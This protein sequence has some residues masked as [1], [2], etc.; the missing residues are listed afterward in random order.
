MPAPIHIIGGGLAGS[1]AAWQIAE[2][3]HS[4]IL[5]E[6]RPVV[7]TPAH[8][9][10]RFAELV[11]SN[12]LKSEQPDTAPWLLKQELRRLGSL[13]LEAAAHARVPGG[14]ALTVDREVFSTEITRAIAA[15]PRIEVRREEVRQIDDQAGISIVASGPLTSDTL[16]GEIARLTGSG[17]LFFYDSISPIVEADSVDLTIAFRASRY[18]KS[19]DGTRRLSE[20]PVRSPSIRSLH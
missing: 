4:A 10:D 13:V 2:S 19:L 5:H 20:L 6:M 7:Q 18:G 17:R 1:E 9:T 11:C 3:G 8:Q 15:H 12:S 16:A 14:Q